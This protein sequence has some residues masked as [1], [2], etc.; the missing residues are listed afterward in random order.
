MAVR[1]A[2][3]DA[4][5][6]L[7]KQLRDTLR[8]LQVRLRDELA[9]AATDRARELD[10]TLSAATRAAEAARDPAPALAAIAA[11]L[12]EL[13]RLRTRARDLGLPPARPAATRLL[14]VVPPR[15]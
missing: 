2:V 8:D 9:A 1:G 14:S 11:D 13:D 10:R 7:G 6:A 4:S 15:G 12:G 5:M 3:D